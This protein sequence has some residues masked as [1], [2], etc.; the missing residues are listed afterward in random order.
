MLYGYGEILI[1]V[2]FWYVVFVL[3]F[4]RVEIWNK[5]VF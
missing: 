1:K 4:I 3:K 2:G 5:I